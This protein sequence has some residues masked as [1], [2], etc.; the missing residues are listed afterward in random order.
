MF[1]NRGIAFR[2]GAPLLV[3]T[4]MIFLVVLASGYRQSRDLILQSLKQNA[5]NL[6]RSTALRIESVLAPVEKMPVGIGA[7]LE[8]VALNEKELIAVLGG[9]LD[10]NPDVFGSVVAF[11][12]YG[13]D[14][15]RLYYAPYLARNGSEVRLT[16][17]GEA[18]YHYFY[19]DWYQVPRETR[20][21][22]W[23]EPY[24]DEGGGNI[25]MATFSAPFYREAQGERRLAG[26]VTADI[27]LEWL[28]EVISGVR[29]LRSGYS[30]IVSRTGTFVA[31]PEKRWLMNETI[32]SIAEARGDS[33]LRQI[34][35]RMISGESGFVPFS[36][37]FAQRAGF[38]CFTP[39]GHSRWSLG[40]F[41]PQDELMSDLT[42]FNRQGVYLAACGV[43]LLILVIWLVS[44]TITRP[45][46]ALSSAAREMA[47]GNLDIDVPGRQSGGEVRVLAESFIY[48]KDALKLHIQHLVETTAARER[49]ESELN[50]A[51]DI[52][53]GLLP[54]LFPPL[55]DIPEMDLYAMIQPARE[56]G[57]DLYDFYRIDE[58]RICFV[59]GDVSGKGV[60]ASL[61]MAVTMTLIKMT[62]ATGV[63]PDK[64]LREVNAHLSRD[65]AASM[66]VTLFCGILDVR[67][68]ELWYANGGHNLPVLLRKN[69]AISF[70]EGT[71]GVLLGAVEDMDYHMK[72]TFLEAGDGVLLYSDGVTEAMNESEALYSD[73]RLLALVQDLRQS[74]AADLVEGVMRSV[75]DFAGTAPQADDITMMMVRYQGGAKPVPPIDR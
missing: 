64:I 59:L 32:F 12:P 13:F 58:T 63:S 68:G 6:A 26:V 15:S 18:Q 1:R 27:S 16:Y 30:F 50:I 9:A 56:V 42:E 33:D 51:R 52:Q 21:A 39:I 47:T 37:D 73:E 10:V 28:K 49:I 48:M 2:I 45:L 43:L 31:H 54:K 62:A 75:L 5:Q 19:Q 22:C 35:R 4:V 34:G 53:M 69:G 23:S 72:R 29:I 46:T 61:F 17:L 66:F 70:L 71:E 40:I 11:E 24:Y 74:T 67:N 7:V 8:K 41:F 14:P 44:G 65:N 55:P 20:A 36:G 3:G 38:L 25:L 60:P 57:G